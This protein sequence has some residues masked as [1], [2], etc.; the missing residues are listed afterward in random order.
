MEDSVALRACFPHLFSSLGQESATDSLQRARGLVAGVVE[1][2]TPW[3]ATQKRTP[4]Y[5]G[6]QHIQNARD[7]Q[8]LSMIIKESS[9][10][11]QQ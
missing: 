7:T 8:N 9:F 11:T 6:R 2:W 10:V 3:A 1:G 4:I 5:N